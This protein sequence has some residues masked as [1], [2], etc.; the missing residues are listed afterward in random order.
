MVGVD[1]LP[2][3]CTSFVYDG[4]TVNDKY[5]I[6]DSNGGEVESMC[7]IFIS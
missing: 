7:L 1:K 6:S 4:L 2:T 3:E 5:E